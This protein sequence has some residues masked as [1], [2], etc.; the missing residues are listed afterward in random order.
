[1]SQT[2]ITTTEQE[3]AKLTRLIWITFAIIAKTTSFG[4]ILTKRKQNPTI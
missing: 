3:P 2:A 1:M 4:K